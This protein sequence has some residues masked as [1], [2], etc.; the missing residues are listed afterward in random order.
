MIPGPAGMTPDTGEAQALGLC[1]DEEVV[2][3][4]GPR[5]RERAGRGCLRRPRLPVVG[6]VT[7]QDMTAGRTAQQRPA[8]TRTVRGGGGVGPRRSPEPGQSACRRS[9]T[10]R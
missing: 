7:A 4:G 2:C 5:L 8:N 3:R 1:R 6:A 9:V 10:L